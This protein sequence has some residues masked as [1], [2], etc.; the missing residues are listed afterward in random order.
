[1]SVLHRDAFR[2]THERLSA[3]TIQ[4]SLDL[5]TPRGRADCGF[6]MEE[7]LDT[8]RGFRIRSGGT[9]RAIGYLRV[10]TREQADSGAGLMAQQC[11]IESE[12]ARRGWDLIEI[13]TDAGASGKSLRGR[14]ALASAIGSVEQGQADCLMVAKVDRLSRS[15]MDFATL[16]DRSRRKGWSLVALDLGVDTTTPAGEMIASVMASFAQYERRLIAQRTKDALAV[17]KEAGVRLGRPRKVPCA[18]FARIHDERSAGATLRA[19]AQSL[20]ADGVP[21]AHGGRRWYPATVR[22]ILGQ[23]NS[24]CPGRCLTMSEGLCAT[25]CT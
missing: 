10:S 21:T 24:T 16:M 17:K 12:C 6:M 20:E 7:D 18:V 3:S 11:A 15:L 25:R 4:I 2:S 13:A 19:I 22:S 9:V 8:K 1:M 5:A 14:P 23:S